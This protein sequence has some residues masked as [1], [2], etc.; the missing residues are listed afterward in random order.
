MNRSLKSLVALAGI[1]TI[2]AMVLFP[3]AYGHGSF[4]AVNGPT[5]IF[6]SLRAALLILWLV[7]TLGSIVT[8]RALMFH[9][10]VPLEQQSHQSS[11]LLC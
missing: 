8:A 4:Q 3:A 10:W 7:V 2:V 11:P 6:T 5:T 9:S 1:V